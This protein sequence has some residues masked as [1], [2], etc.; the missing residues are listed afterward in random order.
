MAEEGGA[1]TEIRG[2]AIGTKCLRLVHGPTNEPLG[3]PGLAVPKAST[4]SLL[5]SFVIALNAYV[6]LPT[7]VRAGRPEPSGSFS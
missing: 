4:V 1:E 6:Y 7:K 3:T 5:A 2:W